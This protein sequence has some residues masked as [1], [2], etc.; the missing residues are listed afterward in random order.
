MVYRYN[1]GGV[2]TPIRSK[3]CPIGKTTVR[4]YQDLHKSFSRAL[5]IVQNIRFYNPTVIYSS[6]QNLVQWALELSINLCW[7]S[8][9]AGQSN[10]MN[11]IYTK[12][13]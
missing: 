1:S 4:W 6:D 8:L 10:P 11:P 3:F 2:P 13:I 12:I 5:I 7:S 9:A